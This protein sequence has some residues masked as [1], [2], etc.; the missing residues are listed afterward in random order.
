MAIHIKRA[1]YLS[2]VVLSLTGS[3]AYCQTPS[4]PKLTVNSVSFF[5]QPDG[6]Y[7]ANVNLGLQR[8]P[9]NPQVGFGITIQHVKTLD[10]VYEKLKPAVD[11]LANEMKTAAEGFHPPH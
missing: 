11:D 1:V 8:G 10:E 2:L 3:S 5:P 9:N 6:Y 7:Q 4:E